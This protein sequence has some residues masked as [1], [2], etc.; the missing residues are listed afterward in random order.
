M[1]E[2]SRRRIL[3]AGAGA[4]VAVPMTVLAARVAAADPTRA[5]GATGAG[6]G[7]APALSTAIGTPERPVMFCVHDASAGE[8]SVLHGTNEVIVRDTGLVSRILAAVAAVPSSSVVA[9]TT[10]SI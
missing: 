5:D 6:V 3:R 2:L 4:A 1:T 7:A 8:V 9:A 10:T